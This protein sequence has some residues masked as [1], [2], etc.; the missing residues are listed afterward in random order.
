MCGQDYV[1]DCFMKHAADADIAVIEG[2]MGMY[3][4]DFSTASLAHLLQTPVI[5]LWWTPTAWPR[6]RGCGARL[7]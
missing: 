1:I 7:S 6:A 4:G 5:P 2:V 3:D